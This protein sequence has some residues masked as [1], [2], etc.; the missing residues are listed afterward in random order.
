MHGTNSESDILTNEDGFSLFKINT[1]KSL[2]DYNTLDKLIKQYDG[3][4]YWKDKNTGEYV[5]KFN[6]SDVKNGLLVTAGNIIDKVDENPYVNID[7]KLPKNSNNAK[8]TSVFGEIK[9]GVFY[10]K[11]P[12]TD[13]YFTNVEQIY[14]GSYSYTSGGGILSSDYTYYYSFTF[15]RK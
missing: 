7:F 4:T 11:K 2:G 8:F 1:R 5:G 14:Q 10:M 12:H 9:D 15:G 6:I 3:S 13:D